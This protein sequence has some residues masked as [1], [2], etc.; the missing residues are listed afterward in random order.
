[1]SIRSLHVRQVP[2]GY[3]GER[4]LLKAFWGLG[5]HSLGYV[6]RVVSTAMICPSF[7]TASFL[8]DHQQV[9]HNRESLRQYCHQMGLLAEQAGVEGLLEEG[10]TLSGKDVLIALDGGRVCCR[11]YLEDDPDRYE[12]EWKEPRL[13]IIQALN[14]KG[15]PEG[16]PLYLS[17]FDRKKLMKKVEQALVALQIGQAKRVQWV[18]DGAKWIWNEAEQLSQELNIP[19]SQCF[20]T[21]DYYHARSYFHTVLSALPAKQQAQKEKQWKQLLWEGKS[22]LLVQEAGQLIKKKSEEVKTALQYLQTNACRMQYAYCERN[23]L[24]CGSGIV[25]SAIRRVINLRFKSSGSFW[26]QE[27]VE[28]LFELRGACLSERWDILLQNLEKRLIKESR[29]G[30]LRL[31]T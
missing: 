9:S 16:K 11:K 7:Q 20:Y 8:L 14:E 25:E 22:L 23:N 17:S 4:H 10:E 6:N 12:A 3:R 30:N 28:R 1:M 27:G 2:E 5:K 29:A 18:G 24:A 19:A 15:E 31:N 13:A 21:L 26:R